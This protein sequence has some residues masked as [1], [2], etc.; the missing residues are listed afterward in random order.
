MFAGG[1]NGE[2][3]RRLRANIE[4]LIMWSKYA[5]FR[6]VKQAGL[7]VLHNWQTEVVV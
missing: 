7:M 6:P 2:G 3:L 4:S 1:V 5:L